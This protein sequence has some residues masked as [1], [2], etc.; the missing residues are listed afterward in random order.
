MAINRQH[1]CAQSFRRW[2]ASG[3][4]PLSMV[5]AFARLEVVVN[6][7]LIWGSVLTGFAAV[8]L[9]LELTGTRDT[10]GRNYG[11]LSA[12]LRRWLGIDPPQPRRWWTRVL[13]GLFLAWFAVHILTPWL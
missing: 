1:N 9:P 3:P 5:G 4:D 6:W 12:A 10:R 11:T 13:F 8:F 2:A 7:D